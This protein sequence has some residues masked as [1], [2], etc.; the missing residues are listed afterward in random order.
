MSQ[1]YHAACRSDGAREVDPGV[2]EVTANIPNSVADAR[3]GKGEQG[4]ASLA[5]R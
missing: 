1:R 4:L 5:P 3:R 2:S